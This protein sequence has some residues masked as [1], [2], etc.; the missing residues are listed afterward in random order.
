MAH[1]QRH[2]VRIGVQIKPQHA[3][4]AQ[5]RQACAAAE[6]AGV[7][8]VFNWD[9]FWPLGRDPKAGGKHFECWTMLG[10][11]AESTS[12]VEFGPLVSAIAYRNPDLLADMARTVD[13][14]SGGRLVLGVGA[15]FREKE[16]AEYG[17]PFGTPAARARQ[18]EEGLARITSRLAKLNPPPTRKIP[19]LIAGAGEQKTLGLVAEYADIWNALLP[20]AETY[21]HKSRI[22]DEHCARI[23]RDPSTIE[24]SVLVTG[25]PEKHGEE[26][27]ALGASLFIVLVSPQ[28]DLAEVERWVAWRD[29]RNAEV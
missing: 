19:I 20:D 14:I 8:L 11:W 21:A 28:D 6:Q 12:R 10:A 3:D 1:D 13:H 15:G 4:Y 9:H 22:L 23:G 26:H 2:P 24:R 25:P 5:I 7:D 27:L 16:Y 17:Y 29:R 18:L